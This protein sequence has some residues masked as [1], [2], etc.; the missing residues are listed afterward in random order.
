MKKVK[1][2]SHYVQMARVA[3]QIAQASLPRYTHRNSP[4]RFTQPQLAACVVLMVYLGLSYRDMEEWLLSTNQVCGVLELT[5]V[6]DHSTMNRMMGRL[7][8][9]GLAEMNRLLLTAMQVEEEA[10]AIDSTGFAM[11]QASQHFLTRRGN[12]YSVYIKGFYAVGVVCQMVMAWR[13]GRGP[14]SDMPYLAGLRRDAQRFGKPT[15]RGHHLMVLADKGFDGRHV[16]PGD[17]VSPRRTPFPNRPLAPDRQARADLV[18]AA[19]L[20]GLMGHRWKVETV[21]SVI[22]RKSGEAIH[23]RLPLHQRREVAL[24]GFAYN[25]HL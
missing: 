5:E 21:F 25:V 14:A 8:M 6:P 2:E 1:H 10:A 17:L 12:P 16:R 9:K 4:K 20:D 7:R 24:K 18:D 23:S 3:Y 15:S 22:K 13:Y 11:T 19:R